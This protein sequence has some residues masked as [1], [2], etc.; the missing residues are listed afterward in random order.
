MEK[1]DW[2]EKIKEFSVAIVINQS[3]SE[4][5]E[6]ASTTSKYHILD[7]TDHSCTGKRGFYFSWLN[8][9]YSFL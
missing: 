1:L 7:Y 8:S 2:L 5:L 4:G 6:F 9:H 3:E